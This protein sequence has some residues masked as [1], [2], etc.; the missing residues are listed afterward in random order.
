MLED[1]GIE[2]YLNGRTLASDHKDQKESKTQM[3]GSGTPVVKWEKTEG[4]MDKI[5]SHTNLLTCYVPIIINKEEGG[6]EMLQK[7]VY[8]HMKSQKS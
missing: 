1:S 7:P 5:P 6:V 8:S 2:I 4:Q 3:S